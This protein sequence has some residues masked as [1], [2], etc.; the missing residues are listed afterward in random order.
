[1]PF[2]YI[3]LKNYNKFTEQEDL[4]KK[5]KDKILNRQIVG[6]YCEY[7]NFTIYPATLVALTLVL[8]NGSSIDKK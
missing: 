8:T 7:S 6:D 1:M 3:N 2:N 5:F 4:F